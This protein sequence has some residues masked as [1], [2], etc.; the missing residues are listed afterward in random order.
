M[1]G[2][3]LLVFSSTSLNCVMC[4]KT[5]PS[6]NYCSQIQ[7]KLPVDFAFRSLACLSGSLAPPSGEEGH[8]ALSQSVR[9]GEGVDARIRSFYI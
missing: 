7:S 5:E 9:R 8:T 6:A 3:H 4:S 2:N 1:S